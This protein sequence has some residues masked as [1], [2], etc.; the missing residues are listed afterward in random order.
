MIV[1]IRLIVLWQ[2]Y[3]WCDYDELDEYLS[4]GLSSNYV[5][6]PIPAILEDEEIDMLVNHKSQPLLRKY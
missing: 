4:L 2:D 3:V 1:E 5:V 6:I